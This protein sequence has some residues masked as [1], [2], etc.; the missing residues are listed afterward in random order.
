MEKF[1]QEEKELLK[2]SVTFVI[3]SINMIPS[4]ILKRKNMNKVIM[5]KQYQ[6]LLKK[7]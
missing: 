7:L 4:K 2:F 6:E 5:L 3:E 1:N